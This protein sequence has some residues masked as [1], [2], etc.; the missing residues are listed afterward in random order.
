MGRESKTAI[1]DSQNRTPNRGHIAAFRLS[2]RVEQR[3][4]FAF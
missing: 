1:R 4:P 3:S 2:S